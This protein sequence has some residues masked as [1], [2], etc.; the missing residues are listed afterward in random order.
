[1]ANGHGMIINNSNYKWVLY[2]CDGGYG[3]FYIDRDGVDCKLDGP[4]N[5]CTVLPR[6][7]YS[8]TMT[9]TAGRSKACIEFY[10]YFN[11]QKR[12]V[13]DGLGGCQYH[14]DDSSANGPHLVISGHTFT[15][16]NYPPVEAFP[17]NFQVQ[18][19]KGLGSIQMAACGMKIQYFSNLKQYFVFCMST[20]K[21][22]V[23]NVKFSKSPSRC[24]ILTDRTSVIK[25]VNCDNGVGYAYPDNY[26]GVI[27]YCQHTSSHESFCPW[28]LRKGV[29]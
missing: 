17:L 13:C 9:H 5:A 14:Y 4:G 7:V 18:A 12:Q 21:N 29:S 3:N 8:W 27:F 24:Y 1:M 19:I 28:I 26:R 10:E 2:K 23:I 20:Q 22:N 6:T 11:N 25:Q 15:M 16:P